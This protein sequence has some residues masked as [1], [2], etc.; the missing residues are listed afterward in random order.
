MPNRFPRLKA[1]NDVLFAV[2]CV[3]GWG[4]PLCFL[5][6]SLTAHHLESYLRPGFGD[7]NCWF[8]GKSL[9]SEMI[10]ARHY[11][12]NRMKIYADTWFRRL[13][14]SQVITQ[15]GR[16]FMGQSWCC[17]RLTSFISRLRA[18]SSGTCTKRW[19]AVKWRCWDS[20]AWC[21][22]S[23]RSWWDSPGSSRS[24]RTPSARQIKFIGEYEC[25]C[26]YI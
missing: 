19:T 5:A 12:A 3:I 24:Y 15:R 10:H 9:A 7:N 11:Y 14:D 26:V 13:L 21:T 17:C 1:R 18:G 25:A 16:I 6:A 22:S 20:S 2:Y 8:N 23:S 4:L